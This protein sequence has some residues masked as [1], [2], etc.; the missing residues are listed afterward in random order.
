[1]KIDVITTG[2]ETFDE[3]IENVT[4]IAA[5]TNMKFEYGM[6]VFDGRRD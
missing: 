4:A 6:I 1:M 3:Y 5:N 2:K